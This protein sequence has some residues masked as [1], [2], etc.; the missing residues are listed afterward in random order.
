MW[1]SDASEDAKVRTEKCSWDSSVL[2]SLR[3]SPRAILKH[4]V[5]EISG[6]EMV[7]KRSFAIKGNREMGW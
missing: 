4:K 5:G 3:T 1:G 7:R 2:T 6:D